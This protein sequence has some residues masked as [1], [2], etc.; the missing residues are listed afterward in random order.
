MPCGRNATKI[1][2]FFSRLI[3]YKKR[4]YA[5]I[6]GRAFFSVNFHF[7]EFVLY[8]PC[9]QTQQR[10]PITYLRWFISFLVSHRVALWNS[11]EHSLKSVN[12]NDGDFFLPD[13]VIC[14]DEV[15]SPVRLWYNNRPVVSVD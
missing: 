5:L 7:G 8:L 9:T 3:T 14:G 6:N 4:V 1:T 2:R 15:R 11:W 10:N 13:G 12:K